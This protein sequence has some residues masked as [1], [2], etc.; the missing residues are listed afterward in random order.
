[1]LLAVEDHSGIDLFVVKFIPK[2]IINAMII[3]TI[4]TIESI[5]EEKQL[6]NPAIIIIGEVVNQRIDLTDI[7]AKADLAMANSRKQIA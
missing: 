4:D 7:Y 2:D 6:S 5:V 1:M 3:G